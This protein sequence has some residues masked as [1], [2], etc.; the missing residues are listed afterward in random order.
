[1]EVLIQP[2]LNEALHTTFVVQ[3]K[4]SNYDVSK[5]TIQAMDKSLPDVRKRI[6][7]SNINANC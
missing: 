7:Q 1:M 4:N 5:A 3:G 6:L 2:Y